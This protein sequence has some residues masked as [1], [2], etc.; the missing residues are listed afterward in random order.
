MPCPSTTI[1]LLPR[2]LILGVTASVIVPV[3]WSTLSEQARS[4]FD[5]DSPKPEPKA[6]AMPPK[7]QFATGIASLE[8]LE[9]ML[10]GPG[11]QVTRTDKLLVLTMPGLTL[12]FGAGKDGAVGATVSKGTAEN[13][14]VILDEIQARYVASVRE[15]VAARVASEAPRNGWQLEGR[16]QSSD[17]G[18]QITLKKA[19]P[20]KAILVG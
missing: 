9:P 11:R 12:V 10:Q 4:L 3:L 6:A 14:K 7:P 18:I 19:P 16:G 1:S 5:F 13:A 17:G 8:A 15:R 20:K 2:L